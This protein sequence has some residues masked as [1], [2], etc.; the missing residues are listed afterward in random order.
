MSD[1]NAKNV[2]ASWPIKNILLEICAAPG[3][4]ASVLR[5]DSV[6]KIQKLLATFPNQFSDFSPDDVQYEALNRSIEGN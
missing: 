6:F 5:Q 1:I 4:S 2:Q 3:W